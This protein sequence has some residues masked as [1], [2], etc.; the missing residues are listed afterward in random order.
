MI[1]AA[2]PHHRRRARIAGLAG[3]AT[4]RNARAARHDR[5]GIYFQ[6]DPHDRHRDVEA[7]VV[8]LVRRCEC[9]GQAT[10]GYAFRVHIRLDDRLSRRRSRGGLYSPRW[11]TECVDDRAAR[12]RHGGISIAVAERVPLAAADPFRAATFR[13]YTHLSPW[14]DIGTTALFA[15]LD[16]V[17][18]HEVAHAFV[19]EYGR[20]IRQALALPTGL[21]EA[22]HGRLFAEV[23]AR[24]RAHLGLVDP[25]RPRWLALP[26]DARDRA[27][28][29]TRKAVAPELAVMAATDP[30]A[31][32]RHVRAKAQRERRAQQRAASGGATTNELM[33]AARVAAG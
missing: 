6:A 26:T 12:Q 19:A 28:A 1:V 8:D 14:G 21:D 29:F 3:V 2:S 5:Q 10:W 16:V 17:V 27:L 11:A 31:Y 22:P 4:A 30:E 20:A 23:Y 25:G 18:A 24:L 7:R 33:T 9:Y 15:P 13:E 32:R